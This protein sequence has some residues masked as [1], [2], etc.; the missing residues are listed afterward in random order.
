MP[1]TLTCT[2]WWL[3]FSNIDSPLF[4]LSAQYLNTES[5]MKAVL[6]H[7]CAETVRFFEK[8][9]QNL[10][11]PQNNGESWGWQ[12]GFSWAFKGLIQHLVWYSQQVTV[13]CAGWEGNGSISF[14]TCTPDWFQFLLNLHTGLVPFPSQPAHRTGSSSFSTCTPG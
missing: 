1:E 2:I 6:C 10:N 7:I 3:A 4:L 8:H 9:A 11:T 14:S 5:I 12:M 13:R